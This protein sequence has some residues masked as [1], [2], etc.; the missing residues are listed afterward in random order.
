MKK[1]ILIPIAVFVI[2]FILIIGIYLIYINL[3]K[4]KYFCTDYSTN[5][6]YEFDT[7]EEMHKVCDKF[8][9]V[10]DDKIMETYSIYND[11]IEAE[12]PGF[13]FY[14]YISNEKLSIIIAISDCNDQEGAKK[15]AIK[16]FSDHSYNIANYDVEYEYPCNEQ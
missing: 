7:E 10:E 9:G 15:R 2:V 4:P 14:P 16:W 12:D 3:N 11:L 6:Y 1:E 13:A 8:N 5:T